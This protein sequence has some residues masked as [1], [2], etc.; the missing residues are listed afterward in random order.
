MSLVLNKKKFVPSPQQSTLFT[1]VTDGAGSCVLEA[2]AGS[3]KTTT[4]IKALDLMFGSIFFG[5]YNKKIAEEI[6]S[7]APSKDGL[8]VAT[9][10]AAGFA[11]WRK[12][13]NRVNLDGDKVRNIF[14][15]AVFRNMQYAPF[16]GPVVQL[17]SLAKQAGVGIDGF[18][19]IE[20]RSTW[21]DLIDHFDIETFDEASDV[22]NSEIIIKLARKT[23][24]AS[25]QQNLELIDFDDMIYAPLYHNCSI[26]KYD[27]VLV[28]EAQDTNATRRELAL[29]MMKKTSR[30]LAVGDPRQAIYQFQ[31]AST[32]SMGLICKATNAINL[33]LS[34][35]FRCPKSVV[36]Y[37]HKWVSHIQAADTAAEGI[38]RE[39]KIEELDA[40]AKIGDV[41]LCRYN[42]PLI[43]YVYKLIAKGIPAK[44]EG[45]EIGNGLKALAKR[46]KVKSIQTLLD[47]LELFEERETKKLRLKDQEQKAVAIE[48]K[49]SCLRVIIARVQLA[50]PFTKDP[51]SLILAE[52]DLIFSDDP[53]AQVV[54]FSSIHRSKG[55]E[56]AK[57]IWLQT[58]PN[59]RTKMPWQVE[60]ES[61]LCYVATTR[62]MNELVL[63]DISAEK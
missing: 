11:A 39:A 49:V 55:R 37:A 45:R 3:G 51:V 63:I 29:R 2:V 16:Q 7:R 32:D 40:E 41:V 6:K 9:M 50:D 62:S 13:T 21:Q 31:G 30:L 19:A 24:E 27:W 15:A 48:D 5:A 34:I 53:L 17:V 59:K 46:W 14:R 57:V 42:A 12:V 1:W 52:V 43:K 4:L 23:L 38:L 61:N 56:W 58:A 18:P 20:S 35:S 26:D 22:D 54:L 60:A 36:T 28:D 47:K 44:V 10:H 25:I 8:N 33:P